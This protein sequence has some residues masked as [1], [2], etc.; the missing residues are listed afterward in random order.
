MSKYNPAAILY[1]PDGT[2]L[3]TFDDGGKELLLTGSKVCQIIG[4]SDL[5]YIPLRQ[6]GL[7]GA[8]LVTDEGLPVGG[9]SYPADPSR[10][11]LD[12]LRDSGGSENLIVNGSPTPIEFSFDA[13]PTDDLYLLDLKMVFIC[14]AIQFGQDKFS[15]R[16]PLTEGIKIELR[17]NSITAQLALIKTNEDFMFFCGGTRDCSL[18]VASVDIL[19]T[20][21]GLSGAVKLVGGSGDFVKVT[22]Q[23]N[24]T[25]KNVGYLQMHV[26]A[27]KEA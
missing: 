7:I 2:A 24:L 16:N 21:L 22:V 9:P 20:G 8:T 6:N 19:T 5:N 26:T 15:N 18:I 3:E 23:D 12:F 4:Q 17:T 10:L 14:G 1:A 13:D 11:V 27:L 25:V